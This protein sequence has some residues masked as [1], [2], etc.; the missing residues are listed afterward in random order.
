MVQLQRQTMWQRFVQQI[1]LN[2]AVRSAN[3]LEKWHNNLECMHSGIHESA[4]K[5]SRYASKKR[6]NWH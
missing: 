5:I 6:F 4:D 2:D 1:D 3:A